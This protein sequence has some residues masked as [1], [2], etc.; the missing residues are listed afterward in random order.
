MGGRVRRKGRDRSRKN[1]KKQRHTVREGWRR[2]IIFLKKRSFQRKQ[3]EPRHTVRV[4]RRMP[5][6]FSSSSVSLSLR[7]LSSKHA[8][9]S[10][11]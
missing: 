2:I 3:K 4:G 11:L 8:A 5:E 10:A 9:S 1:T 7:S 6:A